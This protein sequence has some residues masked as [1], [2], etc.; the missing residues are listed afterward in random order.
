M[1]IWLD[2]RGFGGRMAHVWGTLLAAVETG[3]PAYHQAFGLTFWEDLDAH[4]DLAADFDR[5]MGPAGH[6]T[7]DPRVLFRPSDWSSVRTVVDVGGGTGSLL[8]EVLRTQPH[9]RG[10]L[11]DL[12]RTVAGSRELFEAAGVTDRAHTAGQSFFDPLPPGQDLYL[13][14]SILGDWPDHAAAAILKRCAEA[15][16]PSD[17]ASWSLAVWCRTTTCRPSC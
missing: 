3:R 4:P 2:L 11:V 13:L 10:T 12:P 8:A 9:V 1:R 5:G 14:K 6:G 7:P 16:S 15:A 17:G